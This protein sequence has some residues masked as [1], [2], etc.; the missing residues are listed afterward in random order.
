MTTF[1]S[2]ITVLVCM[3]TFDSYDSS[4]ESCDGWESNR[5]GSASSLHSH[6]SKG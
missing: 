2:K 5:S 6:L 3:P 1:S 4:W